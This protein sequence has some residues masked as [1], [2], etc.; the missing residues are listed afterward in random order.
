[1]RL[2][3]QNDKLYLYDEIKDKYTPIEPD[4]LEHILDDNNELLSDETIKNYFKFKFNKFKVNK[5]GYTS[6]KANIKQE[7]KEATDM[8]YK[9][10]LINK[11]LNS[12]NGLSEIDRFAFIKSPT[13]STIKRFSVSEDTKKDLI[14]IFNDI[15]GKF[16]IVKDKGDDIDDLITYINKNN[17]SIS[18]NKIIREQITALFKDYING[19]TS[20]D[21]VKSILSTYRPKLGEKDY[22]N[23]LETFK[24][25]IE[26]NKK[27]ND[28]EVKE[29]DVEKEI[30]ETIPEQ[31]EQILSVSDF[32]NNETAF[33]EFKDKNFEFQDLIKSSNV[34]SY[35]GVDLSMGKIYRI[36]KYLEENGYNITPEPKE[37]SLKITYEKDDIKG[38]FIFDIDK[39]KIL[40]NEI[41]KYVINKEGK[42][43]D[44]YVKG[45][46][47]K[48]LEKYK[49]DKYKDLNLKI[50]SFKPTLK[51]EDYEENDEALKGMDE[52]LEDLSN[53]IT[54]DQFL[55]AVDKYYKE[56][57]E[58]IEPSI[59]LEENYYIMDNYKNSIRG[60][61]E[62]DYN[63]KKKDILKIIY[64]LIPNKKVL[65]DLE[66][67]NYDIAKIGQDFI[68][69]KHD[70]L[71]DIKKNYEKYLNYIN[72][73]LDDSDEETYEEDKE[74]LNKN[75]EEIERLKG[76][77][78]DAKEK[79]KDFETLQKTKDKKT[80]NE[81]LTKYKYKTD[82]K[83]EDFK[84]V[85]VGNIK[86]QNDIIEKD[87]NKIN[88][89]TEENSE[90]KAFIAEEYIKKYKNLYNKIDE[91]KNEYIDNVELPPNE[92]LEVK[93][94]T[95]KFTDPGINNESIN[96]YLKY[97]DKNKAFNKLQKGFIDRYTRTTEKENI[98]PGIYNIIEEQYLRPDA[99]KQALNKY[100][101]QREEDIRQ[102]RR[103][104]VKTLESQ[105]YFA[106]KSWS[107]NTLNK[108][109]QLN[110]QINKMS[111]YNERLNQFYS[112]NKSAGKSWSYNT[113]NKIEQLNEQINKMS[114]YNE[115]LNQFYS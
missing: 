16:Q 64:E 103:Q 111:S 84:E 22:E 54:R 110:E 107:Y 94:K 45:I 115:R 100:I 1:M 48:D 101:K 85:V 4:D 96:T 49:R 60:H 51:P 35:K 33:N 25:K 56:S 11:F 79:L 10:F 70:K 27:E 80:K 67:E 83:D 82:L 95:I 81:L 66:V 61:K 12:V 43:I 98:T 39:N 86:D 18:N 2:T 104:T 30:D 77:V 47:L 97:L 106:G 68:K 92:F 32:G 13:L 19:H 74:E 114:S 34:G 112:Q 21:Y 17:K 75:E 113:L 31:Q 62:E 3:K 93:R 24:T 72:N 65:K 9:S 58:P 71:V 42:K 108:I 73:D 69:N 8:S 50:T 91:F 63:L 102:R 26:P 46:K 15:T 29:I 38:Y 44:D 90:N 109:E 52:I 40:N 59:D 6:K 53:N 7:Y 41:V 88:K 87:T 89:L 23:I 36:L 20:S 28:K 99:K 14:N 57:E 37:D 105:G 55:N 78:K 76:F 5:K